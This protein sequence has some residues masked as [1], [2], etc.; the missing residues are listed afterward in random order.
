MTHALPLRHVP[1][2]AVSPD[3]DTQRS[4]KGEVCGGG[5]QQP[6][7]DTELSKVCACVVRC[8]VR[9]VTEAVA[10]D[11]AATWWKGLM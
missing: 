1:S 5:S 7:L 11:D 3:F 8:S 10:A 6:A 9:P 2:G 4:Q